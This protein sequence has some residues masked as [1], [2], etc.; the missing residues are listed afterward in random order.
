MSEHFLFVLAGCR[1]AG[2]TTLLAHALRNRIPIFGKQ[3]DA[4]FQATNI[5]S[6]FPEWA[7][8]PQQ[9]LDR[10]FW[11]SEGDIS[12]LARVDELPQHVVIHIDL[13]SLV[14]R[15][16]RL[17]KSLAVKSDNLEVFNAE[18]ANPFFRR[19]D[20]VVVNTLY[21]PWEVAATQ[22][23]ARNRRSGAMHADPMVKILFDFKQP[24]RDIHEAI[25][26]SWVSATTALRPELSVM[27]QI[28]NGRLLMKVLGVNHHSPGQRTS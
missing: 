18:L 22:W 10:G 13:L 4:Y 17:L 21:A 12:F 1:A 27:S 8:R 20:H 24:R 23:H 5:P 7:F 28:K 2:K 15:A 14:C 9:I 3:C 6:A 11:F 26:E 19:F 16:P 25:Y